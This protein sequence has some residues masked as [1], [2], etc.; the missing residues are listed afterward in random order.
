MKKMPIYAPMYTAVQFT[1]TKMWN[2]PAHCTKNVLH[3]QYGILV[4]KLM[5]H[6]HLKQN[7]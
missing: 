7:R 2:Q 4:A 5:E 6:G 1:V 3:A